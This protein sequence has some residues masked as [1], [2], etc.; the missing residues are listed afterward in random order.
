MS[1]VQLT[2]GCTKVSALKPRMPT[3]CAASDC[4]CAHGRRTDRVPARVNRLSITIAAD[5]HTS[6]HPQWRRVC[7]SAV[8]ADG[9]GRQC[10]RNTGDDPAGCDAA[11]NASE[12]ISST[13]SQVHRRS[14][15]CHGSNR[16]L[17]LQA[18]KQHLVQELSIPVRDLR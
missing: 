12:D 9:H 16:H 14:S 10:Q 7:I 11:H 4:S 8:A 17:Y 18:D 2:K 1:G 13:T 6:Q 5:E 3:M 15:Y